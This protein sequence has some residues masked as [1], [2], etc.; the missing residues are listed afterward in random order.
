M[1]DTTKQVPRGVIAVE[2][3]NNAGEYIPFLLKVRDKEVIWT[4]NDNIAAAGVGYLPYDN[5]ADINRP[6][7]TYH[8]T[9]DS[10]YNVEL[11]SNGYAV[12]TKLFKFNEFNLQTNNAYAITTSSFPIPLVADKTLSMNANIISD[13]APSGSLSNALDF[14]PEIDSTNIV[15]QQNMKLQR[16]IS[17]TNEDGTTETSTFNVYSSYSMR[18]YSPIYKFDYPNSAKYNN[19]RV[20]VTIK[21]YIFQAPGIQPD[22]TY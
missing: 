20:S 9:T 7:L 18:A 4:P 22:T 10:G 2:D 17:F 5:T 15:F 6:K 8:F 21:G 1:P 11:Y 12:M 19:V 13:I 3:P 14:K 16:S